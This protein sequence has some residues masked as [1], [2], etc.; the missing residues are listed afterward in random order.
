MPEGRPEAILDRVGSA[1]LPPYIRRAAESD[2]A[3]D[4]QRY[5]TV[6]AEQPG[7]VRGARRRACTSR[8]RSYRLWRPGTSSAS[9][10]T[11]HVGLG[12]FRPVEVDDLDAHEMHVER[13]DLPAATAE[14]IAEAKRQGRRIVAVGTTSV[15]VLESVRGEAWRSG[16]G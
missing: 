6:Y 2:R 3:E 8:R 9:R 4:R 15:R 13:Y 14:R 7:A 10:S 11:L 16:R 5:Q 12:T 1:P